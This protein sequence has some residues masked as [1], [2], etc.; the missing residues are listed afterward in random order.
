MLLV[1]QA[2]K[3]NTIYSEVHVNAA[4]AFAPRLAGVLSLAGESGQSSVKDSPSSSVSPAVVLVRSLV[5]SLGMDKY[6][7]V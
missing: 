7:N 4:E 6:I 1:E 2:N 3:V 5:H